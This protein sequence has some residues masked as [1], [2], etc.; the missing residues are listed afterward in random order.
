MGSWQ[1]RFAFFL[2]A[3]V[4]AAGGKLGDD[5]LVAGRAEVV[6][7]DPVIDGRGKEQ[8]G[9]DLDR[10]AAAFTIEQEPVRAESVLACVCIGAP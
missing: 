2:S 3:R 6:L 5:L 1:R 9:G 8:G 10:L 7:A 4:G